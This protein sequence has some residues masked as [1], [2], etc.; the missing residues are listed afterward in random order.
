MKTSR[1]AAA[2]VC[3][4]CLSLVL[5]SSPFVPRVAQAATLAGLGLKAAVPTTALSASEEPANAEIP[6]ETN[7]AV[8]TPSSKSETV[9]V[10]TDATGFVTGITVEDVLLNA[11]A[12]PELLDHTT[13]ADIVPDDEDLSFT[14]NPDGVLTWAANGTDVY[15]EGTST[16]APPVTVRVGYT[17]D[18]VPMAP[19]D[20]A[21][22]TGHLTIRVDYENNTSLVCTID[23]KDEVIH[24]PFVCLTAAILDDEVFHNVSV[25]N[26][27]LVDD[28]GGFAVIGYAAPGL[29]QSLDPDGEADLDI[30]EYLQIEADVSDLVLDPLYTIVTPELFGELDTSDLDLGDF[31][32]LDDGTGELRDAMTA[33]VDGSGTLRDALWQVAD[34][35]SKLGGGARA[36][37]DA[38]SPLPDGLSQLKDG[39][40]SLA[41]RLGEASGV[42]GS[43]KDGADGIADATDGARQLVDGANGAVGTATSLVGD[44]RQRVDEAT[45]LDARAA[46][47]DA[48]ATA[49]AA[50]GAAT[51]AQSLIEG[52]SGQVAEQRD[53]ATADLEAA[54]GALDAFLADEGVV[55]TDEQRAALEATRDQLAT[56]HA[57]V[58][59]IDATPSAEL[60]AQTAALS[61]AATAL[62][63]DAGRIEAASSTLDPVVADADGALEAL[64]G[65]SEAAGTAS[66]TLDATTQG[67]RALGEGIDGVATGLSAASE[68]AGTLAD[69]IGAV[70]EA[71]PQAI[72]GI[73]ALVQGSD[74]LTLALNATADGSEQLT[75]GLATF[76]DEGITELADALDDFKSDL[77][78]TS[79]RLDALRTAAADYDTFAGKADGIDGTVRFIYKTERIG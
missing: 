55:L 76:N 52:V 14:T 34:G 48:S 7:A 9:H 49:G 8:P 62:S 21:G 46:M 75:N 6:E 50:V 68:G 58:S 39:A 69:G 16:T 29:R 77:D 22:A 59:A 73:D 3:G 25:E 56:A 38:L 54:Q 33:L 19:Q 66:G 35:S 70:S 72:E 30:P 10:S 36:L 4:A 11:D 65:A 37:C 45:F 31:D 71:A 44:L 42:V 5:A 61:E 60:E 40:Q 79:D 63:A 24:T 78:G 12:S 20:L 43:L 27:K 64:A 74:Q 32:E 1:C 51:T 47:D 2:R 15:Y 26:G 18:G 28:K 67:A 57:D 23:G 17:L 13:L 53:N 41:D